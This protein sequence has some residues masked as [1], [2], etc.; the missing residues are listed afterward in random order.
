MC[1]TSIIRT[2][3]KLQCICCSGDGTLVYSRLE[4]RLFNVSGY[5]D[6]WRCTN[7]RCRLM[8]LNPMP[9][10]EDIHLAYQSY[11][12]HSPL[13]QETS[14]MDKVINGYRAR[15]YGTP[16]T[17]F[18]SLHVI[19]GRILALSDFFKEHMDYP[20][21]FFKA[22]EI[23]RML[24]L[25]VGSGATFKQFNE[26]G[27]D[28]DGID[29]DSAAVSACLDS[30]LRVSQ[31]DLISQEFPNS[32][33]DAIFSAHVLEHVSDP[34]EL[35]VES[36]RILKPGGRFVAVTPNADST[37]HQLF[38]L[39]WRGLE[40]PRHLHIFSASA[41]QLAA[42]KAG[43]SK[44]EIISSNYS[45]SG[46]FNASCSLAFGFTGSI[47]LRIISNL[48]RLVLTIYRRFSPMSGEELILVAYK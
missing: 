37:L 45:A 10:P 42:E 9:V 46:V 14:F 21:S 27:W 7:P 20:Y 36:V 31:G 44:I 43:F 3:K 18:T 35:M 4:D 15:S 8:W 34:V 13:K 40:P 11:Y 30:G 23:G 19:L 2:E 24:E 1:T 16:H 38:K 29:F 25:G 41:L 17:G 26:W 47:W 39:N 33:Y 32:T 12:T 22:P 6:I 5:W 48:A 28:I